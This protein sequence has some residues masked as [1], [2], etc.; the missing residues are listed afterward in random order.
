M[1]WR[2]CCYCSLNSCNIQFRR[3][4]SRIC[5]RGTNMK[6]D[7]KHS[8]QT[9]D[10]MWLAWMLCQHAIRQCV[11]HI[12]GWADG[13]LPLAGAVAI[14]GVR[15]GRS[16]FHPCTPIEPCEYVRVC[17]LKLTVPKPL[18]SKHTMAGMNAI[19]CV[20]V[21]VSSKLNMPVYRTVQVQYITFGRGNKAQMCMGSR[22]SHTYL[23]RSCTRHRFLECRDCHLPTTSKNNGC[24]PYT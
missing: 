17:V 14:A 10:W 6:T 2:K 13:T 9:N 3:H 11:C 5:T 20:C 12:V 22:C 4:N 23:V 7:R 15:C 16:S 24:P 1:H 8:N 19:E 21:C 18:K